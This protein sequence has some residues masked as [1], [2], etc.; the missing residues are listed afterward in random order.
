[1]D[2]NWLEYESDDSE[3]AYAKE[4][5]SDTENV[6]SETTEEEEEIDLEKLNLAETENVEHARLFIQFEIWYDVVF[7][8]IFFI[9]N[10]TSR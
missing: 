5:G 3:D 7:H 2:D 9:E 4:S 1:M 6:D 10:K 8:S